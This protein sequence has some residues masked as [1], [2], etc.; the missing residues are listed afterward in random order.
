MNIFE[1]AVKLKLRFMSA[2]GELTTEDLF[3][4]PL[5]KTTKRANV[6]QAN[7]DDIA[8]GIARQIRETEEDSFVTTRK[9][10]DHNELRLKIVK[11]VIAEKLQLVEDAK[12][13]K[14][15]AERKAKL[16]EALGR[17]QDAALED[18]SEDDIKAEIA[19]L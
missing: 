16:V 14:A 12:N 5:Q 1:K 19:A 11:Q 10:T 15:K 17:K 6:K 3:E 18:M 4:L 2:V 9:A 13:R 7:L 8:K